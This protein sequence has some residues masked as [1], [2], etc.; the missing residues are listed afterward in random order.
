MSI[1]LRYYL[2]ILPLFLGVALLNGL[3]VYTL[4]R[5]EIRWALQQRA[6][7]SAI[8]L[9]GFWHAIE[10]QP[11]ERQ[12]A[13]LRAFSRRLGGLAITGFGA[14]GTAQVLLARD[15]IELP[16]LEPVLAS[17][18]EAGEPGWNWLARDA[19][20]SDLNIGFAALPEPSADGLVAVAVAE[21]DRTLREATAALV[22][23]L[24]TLS[25]VMLFAGV[26]VAEWL[27]R[28]ARRELGALGAAASR[29]AAGQ[30]LQHW[31]AGRIRELNDLGGT[32]LTMA[33]LLADG[34]HQTRRRFFEA[35][36][37]PG[38]ADLAAALRRSALAEQLPD[39]LAARCTWRCLGQP[40]A[41]EFLGQRRVDDGWWLVAGVLHREGGARS[42]L[43]RSLASLACRDHL[44]ECLARG[45]NEVVLAEA[46]AC[47]PCAVLQVLWLPDAGAARGWNL[48]IVSRSLQPFIPKRRFAMVGTVPREAIRLA[49]AYEGQFPRRALPQSMDEIA[50][51]LAGSHRGILVIAEAQASTTEVTQA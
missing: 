20:D 30:Y 25:L 31:P 33:S 9:A 32:L 7:S 21:P 2:A 17:H 3:L 44:L 48:D 10:D 45:W 4:D 22:Q 36:L 24:M 34:S 49:R 46:L 15:G 38:D 29:L 39:A 18:L 11:V 6:E 37:L 51:L 28:F 50:G 16:A 43:Q 42:E 13:K 23:R 40:L 12:R 1:R 8:V 41:E 19:A 14:D 35:E 47:F 27:T 5:Q 26:L